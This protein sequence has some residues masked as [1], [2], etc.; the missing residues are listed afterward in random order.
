MT[1]MSHL[2]ARPCTSPPRMRRMRRRPSP[3][4]Q[5]CTRNPPPRRSS[6]G[7]RSEQGTRH[8]PCWLASSMYQP[9]MSRIRQQSPHRAD[10]STC[11][12]DTGCNLPSQA[13][14]C[15]CPPRTCHTCRRR[16]PCILDCTRSPPAYC[17]I[18]GTGS[19][20]GS[21]RTESCLQMNIC[22]RDIDRMARRSVRLNL[23]YTCTPAS[24][25]FLQG[26]LS[27]SGSRCME[28][29]RRK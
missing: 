16:V 3:C 7:S 25:Y 26:R 28:Q 29:L 5:H 8:T 23:D 13:C 19:W 15:T 18:P 11:R 20:Q 6:P 22:Q 27:P 24:L 10:W 2:P 14:P 9:Y 12:P 1:C 17:S 4:S 21:P